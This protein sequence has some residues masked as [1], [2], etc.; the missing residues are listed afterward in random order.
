MQPNE[1]ADLYDAFYSV[2]QQLPDETHPAW[3]AAIETVLFGGEALTPDASSY[4]E[5]QAERN[6]FKMTEYRER[7]GDGSRVTA[8]PTLM[9][10]DPT[11]NDE[12]FVDGEL[13]VPTAPESNRA[14]PLLV[15]EDTLSEAISILLEF[16]AEPAADS[17]GTG[18]D[19]LLDTGTFPG[20]EPAPEERQQASAVDEHD[21]E[22]GAKPELGLEPNE[23]ADIYDGL[24]LLYQYLPDDV[25]PV[26]KDAI[27]TAIFGGEYLLQNASS[28]GEQQR[29]RNDFAMSEYREAYGDG[30][31][32]TEFPALP[33]RPPGKQDRNLVEDQVRLPVA[34]DSGTL[35]PLAPDEDELV[36]ALSLLDE[37]PAEPQA[38]SPGVGVTCLLD[39]DRLLVEMQ[40]GPTTSRPGEDSTAKRHTAQ[41]KRTAKPKGETVD[42]DTE[43]DQEMSAEPEP[44]T[45]AEPTEEKPEPSKRPKVLRREGPGEGDVSR[46]NAARAEEVETTSDSDRTVEKPS[47]GRKYD[48]PRAERAHRRAQQRDPSDVVGL[49]E[50][51][52]LVLKEVDY[53]SHPPTVMGTK[54]RLVVFVTDV[55]RH[56][57][58]FDTILTKVV[59]YGGKGNSA[60]AVFI[61]Y[62]N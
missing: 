16:P 7:Y 46:E 53:S 36:E 9:M 27:E 38:E 4:G 61:D 10:S 22:T 31:R 8:F 14:I 40:S 49:G 12:P 3:R 60:E 5:Q 43:A 13:P 37:F 18:V 51:I 15:N 48:D 2:L 47:S 56:L 52:R 11:P 6:E 54:N 30:E 28:Y 35:L 55:P 20:I 33:T 29:E 17:P 32:V 26:W 59:D 24:Y 25:H 50:T 34:P 45:V 44:D 58:P 21:D 62:D 1:L 41:S 19:A 23:L 57:S 39:T 42:P